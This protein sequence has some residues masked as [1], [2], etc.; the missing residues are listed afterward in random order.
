[1]SKI[2]LNSLLE[3]ADT[4]LSEVRTHAPGPPG[5]LDIT[6]DLLLNHAFWSALRSYA[7]CRPSSSSAR[8]QAS[9]WSPSCRARHAYKL[10]ARCAISLGV[11]DV[12]RPLYSPIP[13][14][15][16]SS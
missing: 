5:K 12:R 13:A 9:L 15:L 14:L 16:I 1:M 6:P 11:G 8:S 4:V 7:Q 3:I 2:A 10:N